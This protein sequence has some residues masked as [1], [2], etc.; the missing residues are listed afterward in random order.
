MQTADAGSSADRLPLGSGDSHLI[1][2]CMDALDAATAFETAQ[3]DFQFEEMVGK[4]GQ[5]LPRVQC[6]QHA[7]RPDGLIPVYRYPG[8]EDGDRYPSYPLGELGGRVCQLAEAALER[9]LGSAALWGA[10]A[11]TKT[12]DDGGYFNHVVVNYYRSEADFIAAHQDKRLDIEHGSIIGSLSV[13]EC[14]L[15]VY[16][17]LLSPA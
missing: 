10:L 16:R 4:N 3:S 8:N 11:T 2:G 5:P 13:C 12:R 7:A 15:L 17:D 6:L 14:R 1:C 9:Q